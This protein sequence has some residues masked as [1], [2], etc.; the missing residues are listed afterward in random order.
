MAVANKNSKITQPELLAAIAV[1]AVHVL[2]RVGGLFANPKLEDHDSVG[3]IGQARIF[4]SGDFPDI[5]AMTPDSIPLYPMLMAISSLVTG[6]LESGGRLVSLLASLATGY[7]IYLMASRI[8]GRWAGLI[9]ASLFAVNPAFVRWSYSVLTEPLYVALVVAGATVLQANIAQLSGRTAILLGVIFGLSFLTRFEGI[10]FV[11]FVPILLFGAQFVARSDVKRTELYKA[12]TIY[13]VTFV[14]LST[15]QVIRVSDYMNTF[16]LNG[17]T[18]W[19][20]LLNSPDVRNNAEKI[21]GLDYDEGI[22]NLHYLQSHPE[23]Q[24]SLVSDTGYGEMLSAY[25]RTVL[26]NLEELHHEV[27]SPLIGMPVLIFAAAGLFLLMTSRRMTDAIFLST[28]LAI[29]LAAPLLH[30]VAPRHVAVLGP[31]LFVLAAT[32]I[33]ETVRRA[34]DSMPRTTAAMPA[35]AALVMLLSFSPYLL[36][37]SRLLLRPDRTNPEYDEPAVMAVADEF[38][39]LDPIAGGDRPL[40]VAR[41]GYFG[42]FADAKTILMPFTDLQGLARF[43]EI[44][45]ANYVFVETRLVDNYPF[46]DELESIGD[47]SPLVQLISREDP[48]GGRLILFEARQHENRDSPEPG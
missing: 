20:I 36:D 37:L 28:F 35:T 7:C 9:A 4:L 15:P 30:N 3:Y 21:Y 34:M 18:T 1:A 41:K 32:G 10:L 8:S 6:D 40:V 17:R 44:N 24:S 25:T 26:V 47:D 45:Q 38:R 31:F 11:A 39:D 19:S 5:W 22:T 33:R 46:M 16:S 27:I 14:I 43:M 12:A 48:R 13:V 23:L 2:L 42:Y 29:G